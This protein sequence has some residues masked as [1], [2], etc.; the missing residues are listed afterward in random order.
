M[1]VLAS[2]ALA[3]QHLEQSVVNISASQWT[4]LFSVPQGYSQESVELCLM[5]H[6]EHVECFLDD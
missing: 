2:I 1:D 5:E 3:L 6:V 4:M